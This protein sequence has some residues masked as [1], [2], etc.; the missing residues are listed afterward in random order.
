MTSANKNG[1]GITSKY[2]QSLLFAVGDLLAVVVLVLD[3]LV[4]SLQ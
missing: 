4:V 3:L 1:F 2:T